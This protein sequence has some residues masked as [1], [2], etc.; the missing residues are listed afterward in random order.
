M[1][2]RKGSPKSFGRFVAGLAKSQTEGAPESYAIVPS[3]EQ[4][5]RAAIFKAL[6]ES[7]P[8]LLREIVQCGSTGPK[9][10]RCGSLAT[11]IS[12][13]RPAPWSPPAGRK[14]R[15]LSPFSQYGDEKSCETA[16]G[17]WRNTRLPIKCYKPRS[18]VLKSSPQARRFRALRRKGSPL[19]TADFCENTLGGTYIDTLDACRGISPRSL[20]KYRAA[21]SASAAYDE[22][23]W[24]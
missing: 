7:N 12:A 23:P 21:A 13:V 2:E 16:G 4:R 24:A 22:N 5:R 20:A 3:T 6:A 14:R 18:E 9:G 11:G 15:A 17:N 1:T 8:D 10:P 19:A